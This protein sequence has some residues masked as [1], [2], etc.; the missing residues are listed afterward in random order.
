MSATDD[1]TK[2]SRHNTATDADSLDAEKVRHD[3]EAERAAGGVTRIEALYVVFGGWKIWIM[4]AAVLCVMYAYSLESSKSAF[5]QQR[6]ANGFE[7]QRLM[8][9]FHSLSTADTTYN[10][11]TFATSSF[12]E[13]SA[14][15][16]VQTADTIISAASLP[17]IAKLADITSRPTTFLIVLAFYT[18]GLAIT[19]G[20]TGV[21]TVCAGQL[22]Y[23]VG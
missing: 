9:P 7:N 4:W 21:G 13:H 18:V 20:S 12:G 15:G 5:A 14:L 2:L 23:T 8:I 19:A 11:L 3:I 6:A 17:F 22:L 16:T 10:Y 1:E